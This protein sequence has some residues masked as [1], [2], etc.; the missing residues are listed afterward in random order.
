MPVVLRQVLLV[1]L[2]SLAQQST[3]DGHIGGDAV[4][5]WKTDSDLPRNSQNSQIFVCLV[6]LIQNLSKQ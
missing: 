2:L 3:I 5:A 1:C 4:Q 6:S